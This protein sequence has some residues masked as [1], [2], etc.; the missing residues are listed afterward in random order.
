MIITLYLFLLTVMLITII[1]FDKIGELFLP[2]MIIIDMP[3]A[4]IFYSQLGGIGIFFNLLR[5]SIIGFTFYKYKVFRKTGTAFWLYLFLVVYFLLIGLLNSSAQMKTLITSITFFSGLS[6]YFIGIK[7]GEKSS[8]IHDINKY[9]FYSVVALIVNFFISQTF[10]IGRQPYFEKSIFLGFSNIQSSYIFSYFV[11]IFYLNSK[12]L[13]ISKRK[14]LI[15]NVYILSILVCIL[16]FRRGAIAA[17]ALSILV[18]TFYG[19]FN[20]KKSILVA[21]LVFSTLF[22][23]NENVGQVQES[24][25]KR[26]SRNIENE[27]RSLEA[28]LVFDDLGGENFHI[29][30]GKELFNSQDYLQRKYSFPYSLHM[31]YTAILHG[32]GMVG[33]FLY[34]LFLIYIN[35]KLFKKFRKI[36]NNEIKTLFKLTQIALG[37]S[38]LT[39]SISGQ[40]YSISSMSFYFLY[41][42]LI[43]NYSKRYI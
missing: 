7:L 35:L 14:I 26:T 31:D 6:A 12:F 4:Y 21:M 8:S 13:S 18:L 43:S 2:L 39:I 19:K 30:F 40:Y 23:Y 33:F 38:F 10:S 16:Y 17:M 37:V 32:S 11:A 3:V 34:S 27:N 29:I 28:S 22:L 42:G 9:V 20:F 36:R 24:F 25:N 15:Y 41:I 1:K 5:I